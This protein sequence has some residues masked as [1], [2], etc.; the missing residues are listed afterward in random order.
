[1]M[2]KKFWHM[3]FKMQIRTEI[4]GT[5]S[6]KG[7]RAKKAVQFPNWCVVLLKK[8]FWPVKTHTPV[9]ILLKK[10]NNP[11]LYFSKKH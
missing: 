8:Y 1:M 9:E 5:E 4:I 3:F 11:P 2:S 7:I 10:K 6:K